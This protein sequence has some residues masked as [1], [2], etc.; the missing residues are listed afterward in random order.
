MLANTTM[1]YYEPF[2]DRQKV[3]LIPMFLFVREMTFIFLIFN[4]KSTP[5]QKHYL[6]DSGSHALSPPFS[7]SI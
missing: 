6:N 4:F 1:F 3:A 7:L 5:V 2:P